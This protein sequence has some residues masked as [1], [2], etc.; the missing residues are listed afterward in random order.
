MSFLSFFKSSG[1]GRAPGWTA[2]SEAQ[3]GKV[4]RNVM[5]AMAGPRYRVV[6]GFD[7]TQREQGVPE[8]YGE[9]RILDNYARG[10]LLDMTRNAARNSSTFAT[11]LK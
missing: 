4:V 3:R 11:I 7:Q 9:D 2:L 5:K 8:I 1:K 6:S 10:R